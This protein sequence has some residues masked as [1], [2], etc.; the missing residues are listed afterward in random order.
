MQ[1]IKLILLA[2]KGNWY[3]IATIHYTLYSYQLTLI[4]MSVLLFSY[5]LAKLQFGVLCLAP[6]QCKYFFCFL[7]HVPIDSIP[8]WL[9]LLIS[10]HKKNFN[11]INKKQTF[12]WLELDFH[13]LVL[14]IFLHFTLIK[15]IH[16]N[17]Q[18]IFATKIS[19]IFE[20]SGKV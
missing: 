20:G 7:D 14:I 19:M 6:T 18:L 11:H 4:F 10:F 2:K 17:V 8:I 5:Q 3:C 16:K 15:L 9:H 12:D 1:Y 13:F